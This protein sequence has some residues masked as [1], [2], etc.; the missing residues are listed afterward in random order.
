MRS[1]W[2]NRMSLAALV[3]LALAAIG[4]RPL[5]ASAG[6]IFDDDYKP[7]PVHTP[8]PGS[9]TPN[10]SQPSAP[11]PAPPPEPT[12]P[13]A[14]RIKPTVQGAQKGLHYPMAIPAKSACAEA[15]KLVREVFHDEYSKTT[16]ADHLALGAKLLSEASTEGN[17]PVTRYVLLRNAVTESESGADATRAL[18]GIEMLGRYFAVDLQS[19]KLDV[20]TFAARSPITPW[21][22]HA[23]TQTA[24]ILSEETLLAGR[25]DLCV[26][27]AQTAESL[28]RKSH[29]PGTMAWASDWVHDAEA[30]QQ[31]AARIAPSLAK[32]K[33]GKADA[34]GCTDVGRFYCLFSGQWEVGLPLLAKGADASLKTLAGK[35]AAGSE[36]DAA[37]QVSLGDLWLEAANKQSG[38]AKDA[39]E[40]RALYWYH[41][42]E[43]NTSGLT[44]LT[45]SK[46]IRETALPHMLHGL[47]A[48]LYRGRFFESKFETR[49]DSFVDWDWN[50][51]PPEAGVNRD[52]F[53]V[54]WSG[55]LKAPV[56]GSYKILAQHDDGVH[57]YIDGRLVIDHWD[58]VGLDSAMVPLGTDP[59]EL[60]IEYFQVGGAASMGLGWVTPNAKRA[61]AIPITAFLHEPIEKREILPKPMGPDRDRIVTLRAIDASIH[62][63]RLNV[64]D[65]DADTDMLAWWN[66]ETD[67]VSWEFSAPPGDYDVRASIGVQG[68]AAGGTYVV[69][70]GGVELTGTTSDTGGWENFSPQELGRI[71]LAGGNLTLAVKPIH[72]ANEALMNL[73]AVTLTPAKSE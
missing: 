60:S 16:P 19:M 64:S 59:V 63:S 9:P 58:G 31:E 26:K 12:P 71:H 38:F 15:D 51:Y 30:V 53:S 56:A 45:L 42:A 40:R 24:L 66:N 3:C 47:A 39:A 27:A 5:A 6:S 23:M 55:W 36:I 33:D 41:L 29:E 70:V 8:D 69:S 14:P 73:H 35:E 68:N 72:I 18:Q 67:W 54:R 7:A 43:P 2:R 61:R 32:A 62:G 50:T 65:T 11:S 28:S 48:E 46:K 44:R 57:V 37:A 25:Y 17:D 4:F 49:V 13:P 20:L 10:P 52:R 1:L 22:A 34:N 21:T